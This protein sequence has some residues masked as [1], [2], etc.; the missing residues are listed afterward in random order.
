MM[1][2]V[3]DTEKSEAI[4][5]QLYKY[6]ADEMTSLRLAEHSKMPSV[7]KLAHHLGVSRT[8]V[9]STYNQLLDE[10]YIYSMPKKGYY[11]SPLGHVKHLAEHG[12]SSRTPARKGDESPCRIE[13]D[14]KSEYIEPACFDTR[15][16]KK[17]VNAILNY[18]EEALHTVARSSGEGSLK[19]AIVQY[20]YRTRN[21]KATPERILIGAGIQTLLEQLAKYFKDNKGN[22]LLVENPVLIW[23]KAFSARTDSSLRVLMQMTR[24]LLKNVLK[25]R[26]PGCVTSVHPTN[27]L[28][29]TY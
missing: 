25:H 2:P 19:E 11:V 4:Y 21:V 26:R 29:A 9:E 12:A 6:F 28:R 23:Q 10:G 1:T 20:F 18:E 22:T 16:W 17:H 5:I 8:T 27:I 14:F 13:F 15:M 3:L 7:R 24:E